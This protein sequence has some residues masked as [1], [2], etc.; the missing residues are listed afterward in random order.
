[1]IVSIDDSRP[2]G[3][4]DLERYAMIHTEFKIGIEFKTA[5]GLWRCTDIGSRTVIAIKID[6]HDD[7]SW[8]LGPPYAVAEYVF[9]EHDMDGCQL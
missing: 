3:F 4:I 1:M 9:D 8:Y 2:R 6:D 7:T 5:T